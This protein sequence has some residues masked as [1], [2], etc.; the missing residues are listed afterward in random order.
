MIRLPLVATRTDTLFPYT[1][2]FR[3]DR[4]AH[5]TRGDVARPAAAS[6]AAPGP[7][8]RVA[9]L[10]LREAAAAR[11][12]SACCVRTERRSAYHRPADRGALD[13]KST[14]LNSSH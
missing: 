10:T 11:G 13:R 6:P 3:S 1:P 5:A 14:R 7:V 8:R 12:R 9:G 2:L 4:R